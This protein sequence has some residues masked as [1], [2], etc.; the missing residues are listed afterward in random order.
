MKLLPSQTDVASLSAFGEEA[1]ALLMERNYSGLADRF[2]YALAYGRPLSEA[3]EADFLRAAASP[4]KTVTGDQPITIK[5][6]GPNKI[7]GT[8]L[9]A[10]VECNVP[11]A[12]GAVICL[13]LVV[14]GHGEEKYI[15]LEDVY[16]ENPT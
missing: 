4:Y 12:D 3:I 7:G 11:V 15:T 8:G 16:G 14:F 9:F 1:R 13:D 10:V 2:G 5:Y 6:Y